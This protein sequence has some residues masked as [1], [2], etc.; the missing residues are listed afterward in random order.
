MSCWLKVIPSILTCDMFAAS[1]N[2]TVVNDDGEEQLDVYIEVRAIQLQNFSLF[3]LVLERLG[4]V[5]TLTSRSVILLFILSGLKNKT[6]DAR[7]ASL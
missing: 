3:G 4:L 2:G 7:S 6:S 5:Q 1:R